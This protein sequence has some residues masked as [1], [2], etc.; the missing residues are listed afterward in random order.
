[1]S[2][3]NRK[4]CGHSKGTDNRKFCD[5]KGT[6]NRNSVTV[7]EQGNSVTVKEQI[8]GN[9]VTVKEQITGNS[10]ATVKEPCHPYMHS[11]NYC[12]QV[13]IAALT[14]LGRPIVGLKQ[15]LSF[16][17]AGWSLIPQ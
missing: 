10:L 3:N 14:T 4:F 6:N 8:T 11:D 12:G 16:C 5:S 17:S 2:S 7:K 1:M 13:Q 9:S 15:P